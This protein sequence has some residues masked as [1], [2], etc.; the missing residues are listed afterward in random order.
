[1]LSELTSMVSNFVQNHPEYSFRQMLAQVPG[2]V[3]ARDEYQWHIYDSEAHPEIVEEQDPP[4]YPAMFVMADSDATA[5]VAQGRAAFMVREA[6]VTAFFLFQ[7]EPRLDALQATG[8]AMRAF[9]KSMAYLSD[10]RTA[11]AEWRRLRDVH[12]I[13]VTSMGQEKVAAHV[14]KSRC[15]GLVVCTVKAHDVFLPVR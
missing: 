8:R 14:G 12:F 2:A 1:M 9:M 4:Q 7:D 11:T 13:E 5:Q 3:P 15:S 6:M 10:S